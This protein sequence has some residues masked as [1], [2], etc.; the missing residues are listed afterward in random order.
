M[1]SSKNLRSFEN[2][3]EIQWLNELIKKFY[4]FCYKKIFQDIFLFFC[5][6]VTKTSINFSVID[7]NV[8]SFLNVKIKHCQYSQKFKTFFP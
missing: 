8:W 2:K 4:H 1:L 7:S 5:W 6:L 3:I